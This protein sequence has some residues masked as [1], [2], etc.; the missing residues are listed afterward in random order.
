MTAEGAVRA[1]RGPDARPD[2]E[3]G[4]MPLGTVGAFVI[5]GTPE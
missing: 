4:G 5:V 1:V 2:P 3:L